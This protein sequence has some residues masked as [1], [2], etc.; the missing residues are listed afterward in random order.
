MNQ[1][2]RAKQI[3]HQTESITDLKTAGVTKPE[4]KA[5]KQIQET[6]VE[7][8]EH[9]SAELSNTPVSTPPS[10][11]S[12]KNTDFLQTEISVPLKE[13]PESVVI[14]ELANSET[15]THTSMPVNSNVSI[16]QATIYDEPPSAQP[17][18]AQPQTPAIPQAAPSVQQQYSEYNET[19][20]APVT[21]KPAKS[22]KKNVPNMFVQKSE[23][24]SIRKSL[25]LR[26]SSVKIAENYCAKNGGSFNELIQIL[27]DNFIEE[28]G[29]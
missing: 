20:A 13:E 18:T 29:L 27:L 22:S 16:P 10:T 11:V 15:V 26:P 9:P 17:Q 23:S 5:A 8:S 19:Y 14:T 12:E 2:K 21:T 24:K 7:E 28:Y 3:G 25:V 1:F 4:E 6:T